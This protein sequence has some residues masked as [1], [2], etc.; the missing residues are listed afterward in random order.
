[1]KLQ[2]ILSDQE[3]RYWK[4]RTFSEKETVFHEGDACAAVGFV[5]RGRLRTVSYG[6]S[7]EEEEISVFSEGEFFGNALIFSSAPNYLGEI[8]AMQPSQ[9]AF[10]DKET[11]LLLMKESVRFLEFYLNQIGDKTV[12]LSMRTKLLSHKN[13][14]MRILYYFEMHRGS[15]ALTVTRMAQELVLPRPSVS[16][17]LSLLK[18]EGII[19]KK[20]GVWYLK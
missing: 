1:M 11:L 2:E 3:K 9:V 16:R 19:A 5:L 14:R 7:G 20:N 8:V 6:R 4:I 12:R 13:I 17:E 10:I 18:D 15:L